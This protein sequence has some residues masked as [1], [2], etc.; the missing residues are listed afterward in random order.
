MQ[1]LVLAQLGRT[2]EAAAELRA[3][4]SARTEVL[5]AK[6][7]DTQRTQVKLDRLG[8]EL[9]GVLPVRY[10]APLEEAR[11]LPAPDSTRYAGLELAVPLY[12]AYGVRD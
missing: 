4:L 3:V 6:H 11:R 12:A 2:A 8:S 5:G 1:A 7:H 10:G 9:S